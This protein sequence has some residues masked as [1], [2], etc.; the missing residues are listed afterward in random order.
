[1]SDAKT[2]ITYISASMQGSKEVPTAIC[3][4]SGSDNSVALIF[5]YYLETGSQKF[6]MVS[7]NRM[8]WYFSFYARQQRNSNCYLHVFGIGEHRGAIGYALS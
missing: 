7:P 5:M 8:Y 1:M 6:K 4:F 2:A 3:K